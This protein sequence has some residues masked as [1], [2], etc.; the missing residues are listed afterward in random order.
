MNRWVLLRLGML[1]VAFSLVTVL[2]GWWGV[3]LLAAP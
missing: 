1:S 2:L 3:P